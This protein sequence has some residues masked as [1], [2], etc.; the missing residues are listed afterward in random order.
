MGVTGPIRTQT[1][2]T[3]KSSNRKPRLQLLEARA[4]A[5]GELQGRDSSRPNKQTRRRYTSWPGFALRGA[6]EFF[7]YSISSRCK[8]HVPL[9]GPILPNHYRLKTHCTYRKKSGQTVQSNRQKSPSLIRH[10]SYS[11]TKSHHPVSPALTATTYRTACRVLQSTAFRFFPGR[12]QP[13]R[14]TASVWNVCNQSTA[15]KP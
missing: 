10:T 4:N 13:D 5:P 14:D 11:G 7:P 15:E 1:H 8:E 6:T 2:S 9:T 3:S 12:K